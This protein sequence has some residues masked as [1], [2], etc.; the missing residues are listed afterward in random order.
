MEGQKVPTSVR[1]LSSHSVIDVSMGANHTAVI[2]EPGHV[3]TFGRNVEGQ[4]GIGGTKPANNPVQV[5]AI[6]EKNI[7]VN[8]ATLSHI[9][10]VVC[11]L[12][13]SCKKSLSFTC[14]R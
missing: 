6:K 5:K 9:T 13:M 4:L 14:V 1:S 10:D 2:V 7:V 12:R 3:L 8:K 11:G